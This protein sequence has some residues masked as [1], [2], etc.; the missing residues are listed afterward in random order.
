MKKVEFISRYE[1]KKFIE[2]DPNTK[3]LAIIS[4]NDS[5]VEAADMR[6]M[7]TDK[8]LFAKKVVFLKPIFEDDFPERGMKA[9]L[10][11]IEDL[12][13]IDGKDHLFKL[14]FD[15]SDFE[16]EN[17]KY[18]TEMYYPNTETNKWGKRKSFFTAKEAGCYN[19]K[20]S[21]YFSELNYDEETGRLNDLEKFLGFADILRVNYENLSTLRE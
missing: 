10:T 4:I 1:M 21:V 15:F 8:M 19:S 6:M 12:E 9:W 18:F 7:F 17:E 14:Y 5:I 20:Y 13:L 3:D 16:E 11:K 2:Q